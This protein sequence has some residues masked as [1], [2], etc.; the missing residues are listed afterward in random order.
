MF[1]T[2]ATSSSPEIHPWS[3]LG[4][5]QLGGQP[6]CLTEIASAKISIEFP[7][8][9]LGFLLSPWS[10]KF[11]YSKYHNLVLGLLSDTL[12]PG[13]SFSITVAGWCLFPES[14]GFSWVESFWQLKFCTACGMGTISGS[15]VMCSMEL[16]TKYCPDTPLLPFLPGLMDLICHLDF[17]DLQI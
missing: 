17:S 15:A 7:S 5:L 12:L 16:L 8:D 10:F 9:I 11:N 4:P 13:H 2:I 14:V 6:S 1:T 3:I